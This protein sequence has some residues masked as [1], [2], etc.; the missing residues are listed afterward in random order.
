MLVIKDTLVSLDLIEKYFVCD[1]EA[2]K[3]ECC[4]EGDSGAPLKEWE[5]MAIDDNIEEI[6]PFLTPGGLRAIEEEG[7]AYIDREGDLVT[8]LIE[9]RN[10]AFSCYS[11]S[12]VCLCALEK[13]FREGKLPALKP[14]SCSL[15]PVRLKEIGNMTAL[16]YD[17]WKLCESAEKNG[18]K[19][20]IRAYQFLEE[21][22]KRRFGREWY[23]E[24]QQA[25][26]EWLRQKKY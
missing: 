6:K 3:G 25:A 2:C 20:G 26:E 9:G 14:S 10:C 7:T 17:K 18:R 5:K 12:G 8:N 24:L 21:P 22:L 13:G 1:L 11:E 4:I 23:E 19:L 16:N 15:Y